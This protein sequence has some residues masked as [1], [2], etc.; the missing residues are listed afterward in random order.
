M[1]YPSKSGGQFWYIDHN[2]DSDARIKQGGHN[3]SCTYHSSGDY[4]TLS[5]YSQ[6]RMNITTVDGYVSSK[7][8]KDHSKAASQGYMMTQRDW[9]NF[10][11]TIYFNW[12]S[13][14][15][16]QMVL[17]G[18]GGTHTGSHGCEGFSYKCDIEFENGK[19]RFAKEQWHVSYEFTSWKD[20][21]NIGSTK[22]KWIGM[23]FITY[24]INSNKNVKLELWVD[25]NNTNV[26]EKADETVDAGGWGSKDD[27][28]SST[29]N[30]QIGTW[31]GPY[32][33]LRIDNQNS[34]KF[35]RFSVR[36]IDLTAVDPNP[37]PEPPPCGFADFPPCPCVDCPEPTPPPPVPIPEPPPPTPTPNPNPPPP[38]IGNVVFANLI[39]V[40]NINFDETD[41]CSGLLIADPPLKIEY[42]VQ[43]DSPITIDS[44]QSVG[45]GVVT[46][47][48]QLFTPGS[49]MQGSSGQPGK[50]FRRISLYLSKRGNP[51][52]TATICI[53][54]GV[55]GTIKV[56]FGTIDVSTLTTLDSLY[57]F[58]LLDN[59][60]SIQNDDKLSIEY[61][62]GNSTNY[63][64]VSKNSHDPEDGSN[65]LFFRFQ[66]PNFYPMAADDIAG[67]LWS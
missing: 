64:K 67:V 51:I 1:I 29:K 37:H 24:N 35:N 7:I 62:G 58:E 2:P 38:P 8:T 22:G 11:S 10:E 44:N 52:G 33:T 6:V 19:T 55:F 40:Y 5:D 47:C 13:G 9:R 65:S 26:W 57:D 21:L 31:G 12:G 56:T 43:L 20:K 15:N 50:I 48:G 30:D 27:C 39:G 41:G 4:Y 54:S 34:L 16:D 23:K 46:R 42:N 17:Y 36:E 53:R 66:S 32:V 14:A 25:K 45:D 59:T 49:N 60:Y 18:R 28:G 61:S 63:I 3:P